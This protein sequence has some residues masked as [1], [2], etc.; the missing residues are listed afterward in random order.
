M[1]MPNAGVTFEQRNVK[2][3]SL[4]SI[5]TRSLVDLPRVFRMGKHSRGNFVRP[6]GA[7][8]SPGAADA[9]FSLRAATRN[10]DE[11]V[12]D[13]VAA[14]QTLVEAVNRVISS[15]ELSA[16]RLRIIVKGALAMSDAAA[17][18]AVAEMAATIA[19]TSASLAAS[20]LLRGGGGGGGH[21]VADDYDDNDDA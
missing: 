8:K 9:S 5:S 10:G 15:L 13:D 7:S 17:V 21:E 19:A 20:V 6:T 1:P 14:F 16:S 2:F 3:F 12:K 4:L 11:D 18:D